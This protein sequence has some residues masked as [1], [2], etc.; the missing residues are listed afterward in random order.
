MKQMLLIVKEGL[1]NSAEGEE[2]WFKNLPDGQGK[3]PHSQTKAGMRG[4]G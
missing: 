4:E 3:F 2:I 1:K